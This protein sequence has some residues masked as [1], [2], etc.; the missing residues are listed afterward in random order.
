MLDLL[1][2]SHQGKT[3]ID[4]FYVNNVRVNFHFFDRATF[5]FFEFFCQ[6]SGWLCIF[7]LV[8]KGRQSSESGAFFL[9]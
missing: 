9:L 2:L 7:V 5:L 4:S 6:L 8:K 3:I 1:G